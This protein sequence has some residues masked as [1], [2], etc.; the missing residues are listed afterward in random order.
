MPFLIFNK[1]WATI[2]S[3]ESYL[4][5][6]PID[7]TL[8]N[9]TDIVMG[10]H[11]FHVLL[12][13]SNISVLSLLLT[14]FQYAMILTYQ[15]HAQENLITS[16]IS[17]IEGQWQDKLLTCIIVQGKCP[18]NWLL[19]FAFLVV[20]HQISLPFLRYWIFLPFS[21]C[22]LKSDPSAS[23]NHYLGIYHTQIILSD[24]LLAPF[25]SNICIGVSAAFF[26]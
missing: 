23:Q 25:Y 19:Y 18:I 16:F 20:I 21:S 11:W 7:E 12:N 1:L 10:L 24:Q 13:L 9:V 2:G 6:F 8:L 3:T 15:W 22:D 4:Y 17:I 14:Y 26:I 5:V